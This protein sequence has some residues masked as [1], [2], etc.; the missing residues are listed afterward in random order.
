V[1]AARRPVP[2]YERGATGSAE[3]LDIDSV[4]DMKRSNGVVTDPQKSIDVWLQVSSMNSISA[5][6]A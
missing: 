5:S 2:L 6:E 3:R 1:A 4:V